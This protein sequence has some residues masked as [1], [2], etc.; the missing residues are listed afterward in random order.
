M[1]TPVS[2]NEQERFARAL[3]AHL[4]EAH[5]QLPYVVTERLRAARVQAVSQRKRELVAPL[6][7]SSSALELQ[8]AGGTATLGSGEGQGAPLWLRRVLTALP[9]LALAIGVVT[10]SVQ[11]EHRATVGVAEIDAELLTSALP[12]A[13][14]T[15]PGFLQFLQTNAQATP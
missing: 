11:E 9:L 7:Q 5:A 13:A 4:S 10:I 12:P 6:H 8:T 2:V 14:Y 1:T 15:D 3:T